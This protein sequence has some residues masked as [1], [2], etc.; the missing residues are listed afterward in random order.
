MV[1][2]G[3]ITD[4]ELKEA[5]ANYVRDE[6]PRYR[7][8][9]A[10]LTVR[11]Y[12][13][14][15]E[16]GTEFSRKFYE[17][18]I[19]GVRAPG[20]SGDSST[21]GQAD[22]VVDVD[23]L[24]GESPIAVQRVPLQLHAPAGSVATGSFS[25]ENRRHEPADVAFEVSPWSGSDG[26]RF[27]VPVVISPQALRLEP[28]QRTHVS[29]SVRMV[30]EVFAVDQLYTANVVVTGYDGLELILT[31]WA[32]EPRVDESPEAAPRRASAS[33]PV[34]KRGAQRNTS[35]QASS[36]RAAKKSGR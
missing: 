16:L 20:R 18:A 12:A 7:E 31:L 8:A 5:F 13:A 30:R 21:E 19:A 32:E 10:D 35:R 27:R 34:A 17:L 15:A 14:V 29:L 3:E 25:L 24:A 26:T 6:G 33:K 9:V 28:R 11:Y 1:G 22:E 36:P 4:A 23:V 2:R